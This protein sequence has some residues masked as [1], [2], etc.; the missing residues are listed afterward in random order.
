MNQRMATTETAETTADADSSSTRLPR[1]LYKCD[2]NGRRDAAPAEVSLFSPVRG[3]LAPTQHGSEL[4]FRCLSIGAVPGD[5]IT[6]ARQEVEERIQ[7]MDQ[8]VQIVAL[9]GRP[10]ED[11]LPD[12]F[13]IVSRR[14]I[15]Q[16]AR[17][18]GA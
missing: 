3:Y 17:K 8:R 5:G 15:V 1:V 10:V 16:A 11:G 12:L 6:T 9:E 13:K 18:A 14:N 7:R 2:N 4:G